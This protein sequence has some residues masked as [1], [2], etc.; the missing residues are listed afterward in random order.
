M[1]S[2]D[3]FYVKRS[4]YCVQ[5]AYNLTEFQLEYLTH[6]CSS[7]FVHYGNMKLSPSPIPQARTR[8]GG[9]GGRDPPPSQPQ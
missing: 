5:Q 9:A 2:C 3:F 7:D 4:S 8:G 6:A 1:S